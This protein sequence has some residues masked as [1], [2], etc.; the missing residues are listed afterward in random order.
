M[1][2]VSHWQQVSRSIW[3]NVGQWVREDAPKN[4]NLE[5]SIMAENKV[6]K[7]PPNFKIL[8]TF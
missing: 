6:S 1:Y 2:Y 7:Q 8:T 5:N 4:G 3:Q